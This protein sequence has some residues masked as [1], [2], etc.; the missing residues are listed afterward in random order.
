MRNRCLARAIADAGWGELR[1][2]IAYKAQWA[3]RT[4]IEVDRWFP[5]TRRCSA[6]H[7]LHAGLTLADRRWRCEACGAEHDRDVNAARN[8]EQ[9]GLRL[10]TGQRLAGPGR[11]MRVEGYLWTAPGSIRVRFGTR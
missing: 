8:L 1:R 5:S 7:A 11:S 10:L 9:E 4:H 6:C 2:Q 3:R